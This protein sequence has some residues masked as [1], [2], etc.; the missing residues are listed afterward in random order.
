MIG[1]IVAWILVGWL[2][3]ALCAVISD[4]PLHKKLPETYGELMGYLGLMIVFTLV[5][6]V[7]LLV[8]VAYASENYKWRAKPLP[9]IKKKENE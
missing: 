2:S 7:G 1:M 5:G 3:L 4:Y 9:W 8:A 6:P